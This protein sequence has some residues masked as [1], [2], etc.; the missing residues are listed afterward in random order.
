MGT[1]D[2]RVREYSTAN[3]SFTEVATYSPGPRLSNVP[4]TGAFLTVH[5]AGEEVTLRREDARGGVITWPTRCAEGVRAVF[6]A[7]EVVVVRCRTR[8]GLETE[9]AWDAH[10]GLPLWQNSQRPFIR[11][12]VGSV[13]L[14]MGLAEG[15]W[16]EVGQLIDP[17]THEVLR[18]LGPVS[19]I[20]GGWSRPDPSTGRVVG[21]G[22]AGHSD[23]VHWRG[24]VIG[25]GRDVLW[26]YDRGA[27]VATEFDRG[28]ERRRICVPGGYRVSVVFGRVILTERGGTDV[29]V[30]DGPV[31]RRP[32]APVRPVHI[33]VR[34]LRDAVVMWVE[35][36]ETP[37][38]VMWLDSEAE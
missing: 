25:I 9:S 8:D 32:I 11:F 36:A 20:P 12:S 1:P 22:A 24:E 5:L 13:F 18:E 26:T 10:T 7:G 27:L 37:W 4:M 19:W 31:F 16:P 21:V 15:G 30:L 34:G 33:Q 28:V 29:L 2:Q 38:F 6:S 3:R 23:L 14:A 35:S 17:R